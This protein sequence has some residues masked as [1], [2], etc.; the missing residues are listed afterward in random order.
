MISGIVAISRKKIDPNC[1]TNFIAHYL[2]KNCTSTNTPV[3]EEKTPILQELKNKA[4][5]KK[6]LLS[7]ATKVYDDLLLQQRIDGPQSVLVEEDVH[8]KGLECLHAES[9][10]LPTHYLH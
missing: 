1:N 7:I 4:H 5:T 8:P 6:G 10:W 3:A 2:D 9:R